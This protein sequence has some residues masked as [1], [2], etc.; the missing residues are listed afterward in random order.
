MLH[1]SVAAAA[2]VNA[3]TAVMYLAGVAVV[4]AAAAVA[5]LIPAAAGRRLQP[6]TVAPSRPLRWFHSELITDQ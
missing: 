1:G 6:A 2:C 5:L 3:L 4:A